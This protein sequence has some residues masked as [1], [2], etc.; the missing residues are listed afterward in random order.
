MAFGTIQ[1]GRTEFFREN[2]SVAVGIGAIRTALGVFVVPAKARARIKSFGNYL[3]VVA[4]WGF[5]YWEIMC[6]GV[7]IEFMGG[8]P[9]IM[10]QVGFAAQRQTSTEVEF[11]GGSRVVVAGTNPTAGIVNMGFSMELEAIYQE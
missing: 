3:D 10:D 9:R 11:S 4:A 2:H 8:T 1:L 6:N 5:C 7:A